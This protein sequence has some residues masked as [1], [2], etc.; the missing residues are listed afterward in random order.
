VGNE[1][2][3]ANNNGAYTM[4]YDVANRVTVVHE[5]VG[6]TLTFT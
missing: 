6:V 2:T 3:A 1:L 4:S 5:P